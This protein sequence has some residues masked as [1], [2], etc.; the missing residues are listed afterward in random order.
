MKT[1]KYEIKKNFYG[2]PQFVIIK[3]PL[4]SL[5]SETLLRTQK[6]LAYKRI[7]ANLCVKKQYD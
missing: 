5:L 1:K 6:Q 7:L 4:S 2:C 3:K